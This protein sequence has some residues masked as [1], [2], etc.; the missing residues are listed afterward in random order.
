MLR[1]LI[2][3]V[4]LFLMSACFIAGAQF[5]QGTN[6]EFGKNRVQY[7]EFTWFYYPSKNFEV[8]YYVG[9]EPLAEY[10]LMSCEKNLIEMQSFFDYKLDDRIQVLSYLNQGEFRQSNI[11]VNGDEYNIGG[12][13]K[14]LGNKMFTYYEGSHDLLDLQIRE[15]LAKVLFSQL[16]YGGDWKDVLKSSTLLSVP[17]W[18]EDGVVAYAANGATPECN[19][20]V[21]DL[22]K[23]SKFK[24]FNHLEG[25]QAKLAGQA[26]WNYISEV[27]GQNVIPNIIYMAQASR[28]VESGFLYVLGLSLEELSDDF[29]KFYR[30]KAAIHRL[31]VLPGD[32]RQPDTDDKV[33]MKR[34][35]QQ[36]KQLGDLRVRYKKEYVYSQFRMSPDG[37]N[38]AYV[39][40]ELGQ[41]RIWI[42]NLETQKKKCVMKRDHKMERI[43]D[44]SFPV[45]AWHPSNEILTYVFERRANVWIGNYSLTEKKHTVKEL[46]LIEK[47]IDMSYSDDGKKMVLSGV[48]R[49]QTD[50]YLYQVIG[51]NQEQLTRDIWDDMH[52]K[53][54][55]G[56]SRIIFTS[57]RPD[58]TLRTGIPVDVYPHEKDVYIYDLENRSKILERITSTP[59]VDEDF[60]SGYL[61]KHFTYVSNSSG[62]YN[63]YLA[64]VDSAITTIDTAIHY[65]YFTVSNPLTSFHR[66]IVDYQF[67]KSA[68]T[69]LTEFKK[70]N[71][72]WIYLGE[73]SQDTG[74]RLLKD[75]S[76]DFTDGN[77]SE[78]INELKL[79]ADTLE[80]GE[81]DI[82][83]Y[84]F[85]DE[86][87]DYEYEKESARVQEIG[88][89]E[90][91][92]ADSIVPFVLPR[93][94]N[95]RL[96]FAA[97]KAVF[98]QA[99]NTFLNP[100]YQ[101]FTGS[102]SS[103]SPGFSFL[104]QFGISDLFE[105]YKI[106]GGF[107]T[108]LTLDNLEYGISLEKLKDR[109]DKKIIFSRQV[110]SA[111]SGYNIYKIQSNDLA[112][113]IRFPFSEVSSIRFRFDYR[114]DRII[115]QSNDL[116]SLADPNVTE[117]N[118]AI[119]VEYIFDNVINKGLNL[120]NGLRFKTW[121]E[122]YQQP[123]ISK[124][125]DINIVGFDGRFYKKIHRSLIAAFRFAGTTSFGSQKVMNY[126]GGVDNW[127]FQRVDDS[128]PISKTIP[129]RFQSFI[130]PVRGFYVNARN[131]N[132]AIVANAEVRMPLFK[133]FFNKPIK[134]DFIENFQV[135]TFMD[136][137]SA[138]TGLNPYSD[139]N[140]FNKTEV[141]KLPVTVTITNNREP[142]IYGYGF[143][144]RS[145]LLGYFV[146][147]DWAWG[148]D[149][150]RRLDRVF[151]L[152]LNLDF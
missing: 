100:V 2:K 33:A 124:K 120:Y 68:G 97:D 9:G 7:R 103:I 8:Y 101:N 77:K 142:L 111:Q 140:L 118:A 84:V 29:K 34:W 58:D 78:G 10:T 51:N 52:P 64:T 116:V 126:F 74:Q 105:D 114:I 136:A 143:G 13:A 119:K 87:A 37:K 16:M 54:I 123:D 79:S 112:Y 83:N 110:Q 66:D 30:D 91:I 128:T 72:P 93:S 71:Q 14:I 39:T 70:R 35:K 85:E 80:V 32:N 59:D 4:F 3:I 31:E 132:S 102:P 69:Y 44:E 96:N 75:A 148:I 46:F 28:N 19:T 23:D 49:G 141:T 115:H 109:L 1:H 65:R 43:V 145:R 57:D 26:F 127:M 86:R 134:S 117:M 62:S 139:D 12:S 55:D 67:N 151:Y 131:G 5:Y 22:V 146:R 11:G 94:R 150:G 25:R 129:Y 6:M 15:S 61:D 41:Y 121:V 92:S 137:G 60:A 149:D 106:V 108:N 135:I 47:V 88:N 99:G 98:L 89:E 147:A 38:V 113:S 56:N 53:F 40:N 81:V 20:Y 18:Y 42:Y 133:Y 27:Y 138:W 45:L 82:N 50:L 48:N 144:I 21:R 107:R 17:K 122:R 24:S 104:N 36:Q 73:R 152:S 90:T 125:T 130:G 76:S 95:Y 63:R